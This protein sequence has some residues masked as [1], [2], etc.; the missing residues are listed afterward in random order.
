MLV[1]PARRTGRVAS[2]ATPADC[3]RSAAFR[4]PA[5]VASRSSTALASR[6][7]A[8]PFTICAQEAKVSPTAK[9][10]WIKVLADSIDISPAAPIA[11]S[12]SVSASVGALDGTWRV[13]CPGRGPVGDGLGLGS[14][15][16]DSLDR[17]SPLKPAEA[18]PFGRGWSR[19][20]TCSHLWE[21]LTS[22][23][24]SLTTSGASR[25]TATPPGL[26]RRRSG[27]VPG[28]LV[29]VQ[30]LDCELSRLW[31]RGRRCSPTGPTRGVALHSSPR[32]RG[33]PFGVDLALG[34]PVAR[35]A[36]PSLLGPRKGDL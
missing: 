9:S 13:S 5:M 3:S 30:V 29:R 21:V 26:S 16:R 6:S 15:H 19:A 24:G 31:G 35:R 2:A 7:A 11:I 17:R 18:N 32:P 34:A 22:V 4:T 27:E 36:R 12:G 25:T 28:P 14:V 10:C 20:A 33:V 1:S 23:D 8:G